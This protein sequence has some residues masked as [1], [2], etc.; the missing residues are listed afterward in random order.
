MADLGHDVYITN[1]RGN[2]FSTGHVELDIEVDEEYW[3]FG[4]E[5]FSLDVLASAKTMIEHAGTGK[6]WY[7]GYS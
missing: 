5:S 7:F 4:L 1:N 6:G 2:K 3:Q